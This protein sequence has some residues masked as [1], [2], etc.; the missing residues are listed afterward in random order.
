MFEG[1]FAGRGGERLASGT[2][3]SK[4]IRSGARLKSS[5]ESQATKEKT[6]RKKRGFA[7]EKREAR[8]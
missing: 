1:E 8:G 5:S 4:R 2:C 7:R 6:H 3:C